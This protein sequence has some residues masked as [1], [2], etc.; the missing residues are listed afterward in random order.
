MEHMSEQENR[1]TER[2]DRAL[3]RLKQYYISD[4]IR[5]EDYIE[6]TSLIAALPQF[7]QERNEAVAKLHK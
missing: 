6:F 4:E 3:K 2:C 1:I 7:V 5:K